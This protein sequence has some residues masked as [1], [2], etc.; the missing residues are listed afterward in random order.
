MKRPKRGISN[1]A[2]KCLKL[3]MSNS[4]TCAQRSKLRGSELIPHGYDDAGRTQYDDE[5]EIDDL[6]T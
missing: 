4:Q 3:K 2:K 6:W 5:A 1:E